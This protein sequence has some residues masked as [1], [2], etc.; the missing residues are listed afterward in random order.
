MVPELQGFTLVFRTSHQLLHKTLAG[1]TQEQAMERR[2]DANPILWIAAHAVAT[3]ANFARAIGGTS[4]VPWAKQFP[5]GGSVNDVTV[6]PELDDVRARWDEVHPAFM[7][8]LETITSA[9]LA[10]ESP[11]PGLDKTLLGTIS[12][13]ALHDVYHIGQLAAA[14]RVYG[15]ERVVG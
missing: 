9:Q 8:H 10:A 3:R 7:A 14:R 12:L 5:R 2:G 6:W 11:A 13:A 4:D 1:L 15:L